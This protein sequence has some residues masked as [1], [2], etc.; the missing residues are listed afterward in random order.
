ML[1]NVTAGTSDLSEVH[2][3]AFGDPAL[4]AQTIKGLTYCVQACDRRTEM[5]CQPGFF[6]RVHTEQITCHEI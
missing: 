2:L 4:A 1:I 5:A 3:A 6:S